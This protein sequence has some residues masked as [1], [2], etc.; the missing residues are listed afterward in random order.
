MSWSNGH[1]QKFVTMTMA[2]KLKIT[3]VKWSELVSFGHDHGQILRIN[4]IKWSKLVTLTIDHGKI[5]GG[6]GHGEFFDH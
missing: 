3:V 5:S 6:Q 1:G 4:V 2:K